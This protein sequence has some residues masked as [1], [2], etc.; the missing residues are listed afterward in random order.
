M[1]P[2]RPDAK[3]TPAGLRGAD[4]T[5]TQRAMLLGLAGEWVGVLNDVHA[6]ERIETTR[7]SLPETR[8]AWC[9]PMTHEP[10]MNGES[11]FRVH[12]PNLLIEHAPQGNQGGY[13]WHVHTVMRDLANDYGRE[14]TG[15]TA[16]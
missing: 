14:W 3:V 6:A 13:K 12:G 2:G 1:G 4:M 9:G 8:F 15:K 7:A 16:S 5:A 11:Y 10:D